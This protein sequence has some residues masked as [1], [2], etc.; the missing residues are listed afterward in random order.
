MQRALHSAVAADTLE[1]GYHVPV[2][3]RKRMRALASVLCTAAVL[4]LTPAC[5]ERGTDPAAPGMTA[6][7]QVVFDGALTTLAWQQTA[8]DLVVKYR[9]D[10]LAATRVYGLVSVARYAG[11]VDASKGG[12]RRALEAERGAIAGAS[13]ATLTYL[14][15]LE[16]AF[17]E[18][19][20]DAQ[21]AER[22]GRPH[23]HFRRGVGAGRAAAA[24]LIER[25][26]TD[27]FGAA[28]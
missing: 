11:L 15:P 8:R 20:V 19:L 17:L 4:A 24:R 7:S 10:P 13:A 1:P 14:F 27:G 26:R 18:G 28:W 12:G 23:P 6:Q 21:Q 25:A 16:E 9:Q 2:C 22:P 3:A 5:T